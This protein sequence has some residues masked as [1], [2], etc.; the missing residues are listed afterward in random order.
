MK[1]NPGILYDVDIKRFS[2]G[3]KIPG[4]FKWRNQMKGRTAEN[5]IKFII[6]HGMATGT[7]IF[8]WALMYQP[9]G[10]ETFQKVF[11]HENAMERLKNILSRIQEEDRMMTQSIRKDAKDLEGV[12]HGQKLPENK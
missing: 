7:E 6:E 12:L 1:G 10:R 3:D 4:V 9:N 8:S 5:L 2:K 11:K